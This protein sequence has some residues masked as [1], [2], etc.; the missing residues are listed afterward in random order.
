[1][2][3]VLV[4]LVVCSLAS[5]ATAAMTVE[6]VENASP[7]A[8]LKSYT[9]WF[10]GDT[11]DDALAGFSGRIAGSLHQVWGFAFGSWG[12]TPYG[13]SVPA[14]DKDTRLLLNQ[15]ALT[16]VAGFFPSE[17]AT[18][19]QDQGMGIYYGDGS[20]LAAT[21]TTDMLFAITTAFQQTNTEFARVVI[22][23]GQAATLTGTAAAADEIQKLD[24]NVNIPE[25][26]TLTL[27]AFGLGAALIRRRR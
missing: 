21:A 27:L 24:L 13:D 26:A 17:D 25:P 4:A 12:P 19:M 2:R 1:M 15:G 20:Y 7:G 16:S 23:V 22:P 14:D 5:V 18:N 11:A 10:K 6:V 9:I 8:G 3:K